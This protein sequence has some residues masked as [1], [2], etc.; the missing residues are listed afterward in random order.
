MG[1]YDG[2][3]K[4]WD[5]NKNAYIGTINQSAKRISTINWANSNIFAYGSKD[6]TINIC[7]IRVTNYA[8]F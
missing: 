7:D 4:L 8:V 3:L 1:S 5:Y 6:K 2:I